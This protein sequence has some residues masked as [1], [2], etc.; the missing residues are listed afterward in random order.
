MQKL[1]F[2][3]IV[4]CFLIAACKKTETPNVTT[5]PVFMVTSP[6]T[7]S[8][9][10]TAGLKGVYHFTRFEVK[11]GLVKSI[12][13]FSDAS[14][15]T[16]DCPGSLRFE[17]LDS[18]SLNSFFESDSFNYTLLDT[19]SQGGLKYATTL[20]WRN[21]DPFPENNLTL[22]G[23][24]PMSY[25]SPI[26]KVTIN[27]ANTPKEILL[28]SFGNNGLQASTQRTIL[29]SDTNAYPEVVI[30]VVRD[31]NVFI[32]T[33]LSSSTIL[34]YK[35][36]NGGFLPSIT[37]DS[38]TSQQAYSVKVSNAQGD[39]A[40]ASV[41]NFFS[42]QSEITTPSFAFSAVPI[43]NPNQI[44]SVAIQWVDSEG[45]VWRSDREKQLGSAVFKVLQSLPYEPNEKGDK[46]R[47]LIVQF[48]CQLFSENGSAREFF[49]N[50]VIA[51]AL[52]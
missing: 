5:D 25:L 7:V 11:D 23:A 46:T 37:L 19:Q 40:M 45:I 26:T 20:T 16:G 28:E 33:A 36:S 22:L 13:A 44:G 48:S 27:L 1:L 38:L 10:I 51:I 24:N 47:M 15:P 52:N 42:I 31:V 34:D 17:F 9:L 8:E 14:C 39:S 12:S 49:G 4:F 2:F 3:A 6:D 18:L 43:L 29:P 32:L 50:G 41:A 21:D 30:Q 35:W